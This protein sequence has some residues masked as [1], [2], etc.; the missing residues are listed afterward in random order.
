MDCDAQILMSNEEGDIVGEIE[1]I[2]GT[3]RMYNAVCSTDVLFLVLKKDVFLNKL[4]I[5]DQVNEII[6][7]RK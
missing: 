3:Q 1:A 4:K 6:Q 5:Y 2:D 7:S